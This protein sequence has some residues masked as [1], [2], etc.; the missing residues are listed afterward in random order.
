[1]DATENNKES[2]IFDGKTI[3]IAD[4]KNKIALIGLLPWENIGSVDRLYENSGVFVPIVRNDLFFIDILRS[5]NDK[6]LPTILENESL[7]KKNFWKI[8]QNISDKNLYSTKEQ[9]IILYI[10]KVSYLPVKLFLKNIS[11]DTKQ[12]ES[13]MWELIQIEKKHV[14][15]NHDIFKK[16]QDYKKPE[17]VKLYWNNL[18]EIPEYPEK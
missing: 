13:E 5:Y 10:D 16:L 12:E 3:S 2:V 15:I 17:N 14:K 9:Y 11:K 6:K 8:T 18:M 4:H 1:M 7:A